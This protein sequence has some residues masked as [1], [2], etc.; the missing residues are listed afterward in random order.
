LTRRGATD[1]KESVDPTVLNALSKD[2]LIVLLLAQAAR[3]AE[4]ERRLGLNSS[5]SGKPPSIDGL[6]KPVRVSS[7]RVASGK[8]P[9]GQKGHPGETLRRTATP[10]VTL[11]H[12]PAACAAGGEPLTAAIATDHV[13]RQVFDLP[14][15]Q[16]LIVTEH[17]VRGCRCTACGTNTRAAFPTGVTAPVQY[18][19]RIAAFVVYLLH[20][21]LLPEKRLT[22]LMADLFGGEAGERDHR[23]DRPGLCR[24]LQGFR[25]HRARPRSSGAGQAHG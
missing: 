17:R 14:E 11:N 2:A 7:L 16:P 25:R 24:A 12:Y 9:G 8:K 20:Y 6:A 5:N 1:S 4:L 10:D 19:A 18:G 22:A 23:P 13:A 3:L 21:Q 15:P